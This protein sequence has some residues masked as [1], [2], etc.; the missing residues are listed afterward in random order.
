MKTD[1]RFVCQAIEGKLMSGEETTEVKGVT[2]DSRSLS[3]GDL[4]FALRGD[5]FDGHDFVAQVCQ[6]G[7]AAAVVSRWDETWAHSGCGALVLVEDTLQALQDL[8]Y[9]WR[10]S[11]DVPLVAI[12]GSVGKTTTRDI[13]ASCL[14]TKWKTLKTEAN[15]NNDI[16]LPMT[17][18]RLE[19]S[20]QAAAVELAMRKR[21]EIRRLVRI[22]RPTAAIITNVEPVHMETLG[23]LENIARA[24]CEILESVRDF[25][26][27]HGDNP[28][29]G[30]AAADYTCRQYTFGYNKTCDFQLLSVAVND[31]G[32]IMEIRLLD[33]EA[34][35]FFPIPARK[36]ALNVLAAIAVCYLYQIDY[37]LIQQ[38]LNNYHPTGN[39]LNMTRL[40]EG[41]IL[42]NDT[43][44]ANPVSVIAAME[45]GRELAQQRSRFV[46]VL[47]DMFELG[48]YEEAGHREVGRQAA[49]LGV[50]LLVAVGERSRFIVDEA[51]KTGLH[52]G[53]VYHFSRKEDSVS[54]LRR[55]VSQRDTVL[56]KASR[57]MRLETLIE[58]WLS[59]F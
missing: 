14:E 56:F 48:D 13:L 39:R 29:L 1:L 55:Q 24:K 25:A 33:E 12:T 16:G 41:G 43:Y 28:W 3:P 30:K 58:A 34:A 17:L 2:T 44:N 49:L 50:D 10:Q 31:G 23:S 11:F 36:L 5:R 21:G 35:F 47:G 38:G 8:A 40:G 42:I 32:I 51:V 18:L 6:Q 7:A 27:L 26:L 15:Y 9:T 53:S 22:T 46:V 54:L 20:H 19:E 4:F 59:R 37:R 52:P 45:T 57:G